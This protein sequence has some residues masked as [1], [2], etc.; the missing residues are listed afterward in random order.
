MKS[1]RLHAVGDLRLQDEPI[2]APG[3]GEVLVRVKAAGVCGSDL[4]WFTEGGIG[5][6]RL[7]RPLILGHECAGVT[8][9]GERVAVDPAIPCGKCEFCLE[10]NPNLCEAIH[11]A[12]HDQDDGALREYIAWPARCLFSLPDRLSDAEGVMLEPL[13]V[14]LYA[15]DLAGLRPGMSVGVL[16][17]GPIGLLILQLAR[18]SGATQLIATDK[19]PHRCDAARSLGATSVFQAEGGPENAKILAAT[20]KRGVDV[21]FEVAGEN[22][23][24]E[25]AVAVTKP[26]GRVL[27]VGIPA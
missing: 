24:V 20:H 12:G 13:G 2:P 18:L 25:T 26:G 1:L 6:T 11:F 15:V 9:T 23:A 14:A 4:H 16:G 22:E 27:L 7:S 8:E 5:D 17:C 3:P 10:G 19:L 21:A